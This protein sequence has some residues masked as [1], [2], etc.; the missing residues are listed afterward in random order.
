MKVLCAIAV[1]LVVTAPAAADEWAS[2]VYEGTWMG[3]TI[4]AQGG[5]V[6]ANAICDIKALRSGQ[7]SH[8][9]IRIAQE[10]PNPTV[11]I[12]CKDGRNFRIVEGQ[13]TSQGRN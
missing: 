13:T 2:K 1:G 11:V 10:A 4:D 3:T 7:D 9:S 5:I 8:E 6:A 12:K